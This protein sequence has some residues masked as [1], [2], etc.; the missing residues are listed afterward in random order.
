MLCC[1]V[2]DGES[3]NKLGELPPNVDELYG[4]GVFR[5]STESRRRDRSIG[6]LLSDPLKWLDSM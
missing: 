4:D 3:F 1:V 6:L 5:V 2:V